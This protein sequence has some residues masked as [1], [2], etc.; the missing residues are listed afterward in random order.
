[1]WSALSDE[2]EWVWRLI[3]LLGPRQRS[4]SWVRIPRDSWPYF[5]ASDLRLHQPGGPGP[6]I[7]IPQEES[8]PVVPP[9]TGFPFRRLLRLAGL[10]GLRILATSVGLTAY[11]PFIR[12]GQHRQWRVEQLFYCCVCTE[13]LPS[14]V[15]GYKYRQTDRW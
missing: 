10:R 15:G 8:R 2:R 1:M 14:N 11:F 3:L 6:R 4:R 7:Y 12:H 5:T 9:G 13:Q